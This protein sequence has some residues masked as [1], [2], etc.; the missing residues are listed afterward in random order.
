MVWRGMFDS[1]SDCEGQ[2]QVNEGINGSCGAT[3]HLLVEHRTPPKLAL[4]IAFEGSL[5]GS[6]LGCGCCLGCFST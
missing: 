3:G 2:R 4:T 1:E 5:G 6:G